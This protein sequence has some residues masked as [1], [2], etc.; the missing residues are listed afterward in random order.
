MQLSRR[1]SPSSPLAGD[2]EW[3]VAH[4]TEPDNALPAPCGGLVFTCNGRGKDFHGDAS[5]ETRVMSEVLGVRAARRAILHEHRRPFPVVSRPRP[6]FH[7]DP[8]RVA[9]LLAAWQVP[10]AGIFSNGEF[11]PTAAARGPVHAAGRGH[12]ENESLAF[13]SVVALV[14]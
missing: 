4:S 6:S 9:Y 8:M 10:I 7:S 11:G 12:P 2:L 5:V 14:G 1:S 13:T 3:A